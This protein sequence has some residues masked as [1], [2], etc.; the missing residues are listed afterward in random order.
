LRDALGQVAPR[1]PYT[2]RL[3]TRRWR[4]ELLAEDCD[5]ETFRLVTSWLGS[6]AVPAVTSKRA[7]SDDVRLW[8]QVARELGGHE[9]FFVGAITPGMVETWTKNS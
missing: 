2:R 6:E 8:A 5:Q 4:L 3:G 7:Y 1:D 9:R